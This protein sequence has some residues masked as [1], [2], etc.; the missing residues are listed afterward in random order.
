LLI[1]SEIN[2]KKEFFELES[3]W[4][5]ALNRSIENNI[6]LT[7]EK[8][9]PSVKH[10]G[11][12]SSLKIL[13]ATENN[14]LVGIAPL[15]ITHKGLKGYFGY[16]IIEPLTNGDTDYMGLIMIEQQDQCL[17]QFLAH[18]FSQTDWDLMYLPD[19]PQ[20]SPSLTLIR[21]A[22][23]IPKFEIE[24][25]VICPYVE[26]PSSKEKLM[27]NLDRKFEKKLKK[28]LTKLEREHGKVE[29]KNYYELGSLEETIQILI[30]LHQKRWRTKSNSGRFVEEK[31]RDITLQT[32]KYFAEKDWL[33]LYFLTVNGKPVAVE[34]N[35]EY[36]GKMYCHLKGFDTDYYKYRVGS[37]LTLKVLEK[38]IEKRITE[39]DFM[40]G[41]EAYKFDW[42]KK[43]RQNS[44][45]KWVNGR[46]FS[47]V[48]NSCFEVFRKG[49]IDKII[50]KYLLALR[51]LKMMPRRLFN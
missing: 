6:F 7:W 13:C 21:N 5:K 48:L 20:T 38:C 29:L 18:L 12:N 2:T 10:L 9:A 41:D 24:K 11:R 37:L 4:D 1:I 31:S 46:L 8:M 40:Q 44:N 33:R 45:L 27:A 22:T 35:F 32:A 28:S 17:H 36:S 19:L 47:K 15:R 51:S 3:Q 39:Y 16:G 14:K 50:V 23:D 26:I 42:T 43:Y 34:L 25:G 30:D 49:K